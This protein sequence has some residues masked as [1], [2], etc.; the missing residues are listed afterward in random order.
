MDFISP[1]ASVYKC[2]RLADSQRQWHP[3]HTATRSS[4]HWGPL[5]LR[6]G[7]SFCP[8]DFNIIT[9]LQRRTLVELAL[10]FLAW[11]S[12]R[13]TVVIPCCRVVNDSTTTDSD[14]DSIQLGFR[15]RFGGLPN[16]M[17]PIPEVHDSDS[18]SDSRVSQE[19]WF[20]FRFQSYRILIPIPGFPK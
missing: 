5:V 20:W 17:I 6:H 16:I 3:P 14:S 12:W 8:C 15:L 19:F 7:Q 2:L 18:D 13:Q 9:C 4:R 11:N 1:F 10:N